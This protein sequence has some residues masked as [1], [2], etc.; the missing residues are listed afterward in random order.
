MIT[1][2]EK[3]ART[4][5]LLRLLEEDEPYLHVRVSSLGD[6]HRQSATDFAERVRAEAQAELQRLI[7]ERGD[8]YDWT[9]PQPAD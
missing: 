2:E 6:E 4:Q 5:R 3:I 8:G 9:L 1:L 7:S